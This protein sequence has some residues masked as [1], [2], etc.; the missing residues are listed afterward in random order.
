[1]PN[2]IVREAI[3]SSEKVASL[4]WPEEVFYRRLHSVVDD[5]GRT[6]SNHQLLRSR[7]YPLQ[8]DSVRVTDISRWMAACQKAGLILCYAVNGKQYLEVTNFGQQQRSASKCPPPPSDDSKC[9]QLLSDAHLDVCVSEGVSEGEGSA[10]KARSRKVRL[11]AWLDSLPDGEDAIRA[12][13]PIFAYANNAGIPVEYL[14]LSW[15]RFVEDMT[16]KGKAQIDWR[17]HYRNAVRG[18]WYKLWWFDGDACQ[19]TTAGKQAAR[20]TA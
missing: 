4:G 9:Y 15:A 20:T 12:D 13:D 5:Y 19:L 1:M 7:C 16:E 18:N 14:E 6:E 2:R 17:A 11:Q 3:L 8:T 10:R